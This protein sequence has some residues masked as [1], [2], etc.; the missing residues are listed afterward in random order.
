MDDFRLDEASYQEGRA[1]FSS[2]ASLR[3]IVEQCG[4][5]RP[6]D[7]DKVISGAIGFMDALLDLL[8]GKAK[9]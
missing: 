8:R 7:D 9:S 1:A 3:G 6:G 2:G 5:A 4:N